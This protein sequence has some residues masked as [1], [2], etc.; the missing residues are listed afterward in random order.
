MLNIL[1]EIIWVTEQEDCLENTEYHH[2]DLEEDSFTS[3]H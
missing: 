3:D 2:R 1:S